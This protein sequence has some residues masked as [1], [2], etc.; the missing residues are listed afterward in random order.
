MSSEHWQNLLK[1]K[2]QDW[3]KYSQTWANDH[4]RIATTC[5]QRQLFLE[6]HFELWYMTSEQRPPANND[7]HFWVSKVV[8]VNRPYCIVEISVKVVFGAKYIFLVLGTKNRFWEK[9]AAFVDVITSLNFQRL[10]KNCIRKCNKVF[11]SMM[12]E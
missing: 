2:Y 8:A 12:S 11:F 1:T 10:Q 3:K 9:V 7:Y 6:S 4:I 5:L